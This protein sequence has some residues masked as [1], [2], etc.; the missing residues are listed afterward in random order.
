[1]CVL[2]HPTQ[3]RASKENYTFL[4]RLELEN[5]ELIALTMEMCLTRFP[6]PSSLGQYVSFLPRTIG[7]LVKTALAYK[8]E[9]AGVLD[10][11]N[12]DGIR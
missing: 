5:Q 10:E 8:N 9:V 1:M 4:K 6:H 7:V 12:V 3:F 2:R 11:P